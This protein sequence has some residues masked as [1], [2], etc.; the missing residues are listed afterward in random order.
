MC[1][2]VSEPAL[3]N[4]VNMNSIAQQW[5][6]V[7]IQT[8]HNH[9]T[10]LTTFGTFYNVLIINDYLLQHCVFICTC[11]LWV[12]FFDARGYFYNQNYC[13]PFHFAGLIF[14][15]FWDSRVASVRLNYPVF[16]AQIISNML[17]IFTKCYTIIYELVFQAWNVY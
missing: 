15:L 16:P 1:S 13:I 7:M 17:T 8:S 6:S 2:S 14:K 3:I 9:F 11:S 12:H 4:C 5:S 10:I